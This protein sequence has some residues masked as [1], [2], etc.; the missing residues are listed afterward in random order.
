MPST[1][2]C[3]SRACVWR[4]A[5]DMSQPVVNRTNLTK[6]EKGAS[7]P[8]LEIIAK[9]AEPSFPT[10]HLVPLASGRQRLAIGQD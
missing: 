4:P 10:I 5:R 9:L 3:S 2:S 1:V 7:Y 6:L 8:G